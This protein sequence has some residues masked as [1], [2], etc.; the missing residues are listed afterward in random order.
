MRLLDLLDSAYAAPNEPERFDELME[1]AKRYFFKTGGEELAADIP[2]AVEF[3]G[4]LAPHIDRIQSMLDATS[5]APAGRSASAYGL[6]TLA[7]G[8]RVIEGNEAASGYFAA[9]FPCDLTAL[10]LDPASRKRLSAALADKSGGDEP[11]IIRLE[12]Q[13]QPN[14]AIALCRRTGEGAGARLECSLSHVVW[15]DELVSAVG[16]A[17]GLSEA[18][19]GVLSGLLRGLS[20]AEIAEERGRAADTVKA[21]AKSILRKSGAE[22]MSDVIHLATSVAFLLKTAQREPAAPAVTRPA[23][24][25]EER[26]FKTASGRNVS[27]HVCGAE[28]GAPIFY[29]HGSLQGPFFLNSF[30]NG[31]NDLG[32]TLYGPS[33]PG[34][35]GTDP[36]GKGETYDAATISD[37]AEICAREKL[38]DILLLVQQGGVSH[39]YRAAAALGDRIKGMIMVGAG[40]PID[41]AAH[42]PTMDRYTRI[43]AAAVKHAPAV[44][45]L[46]TRIAISVFKRRGY[47]RFL[48]D[49]FAGSPADLS[50]LS[51]P[52]LYAIMERGLDHL[53]AHG[54]K[55]FVTDGASQ[56]A[57]WR[58]DFE[59][60]KARAFWLHA[61]DDPILPAPFVQEWVRA[62][63]NHPV[64]TA[65]E[66]GYNFI[67]KRSDLVLAAIEDALD[68]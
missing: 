9:R 36:A 8:G 45:E 54:P 61:E 41:E 1:A 21:Q 57:D 4:R 65:P 39:A 29:F 49:Y 3:D 55:T 40:V 62:R 34:F 12:G 13:E 23:A 56:M 28:R 5:L 67:H 22:R 32:A 42:L 17:L 18:E 30:V 35:G 20:H 2:Y 60:V 27:Y 63:T 31:L 48:E 47:R 53:I 16:E 50:A 33:R 14:T 11:V 46:I 66:G 68:W 10:D 51:D 19:A 59:R 25:S 52:E 26:C 64:E 7:A 6:F 58:E 15:T 38:D 37:I 24:A 43:A 44:M